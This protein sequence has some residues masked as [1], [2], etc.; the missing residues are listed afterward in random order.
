MVAVEPSSVHTRW[1]YTVRSG[2]AELHCHTNFSFLDGASHPEELAEEAH[3]LGLT[4]L[5]VTDHDGLYGVVRFAEAARPLGFPTIFGA[6]LTLGVEHAPNGVTEPPGEHVLILAEGPTGYAALART[7]SAAQLRGEKGA[8]QLSVEQLLV[9]AADA[10]GTWFTTTGCRKG[11]VPAALVRDGPSTAQH[12]LEQLVTA[13]GR[14]RVLVELWDHGDPLDRPR[15]DAMAQLAMRSGTEVIATNNVHYATPDRRQL[16]TALAA[17]RS[18]R[19]LDELDGWLPAAPF[20]HLRSAD[21]QLRRFARYPGAVERTVDIAAACAFDLKVAVP[22]LP[23]YPVPD[24][25]T[26]MSWLRELTRRGA[27]VYY[28]STHP[29]YEQ[30]MRQIDYE[31]GVIDQMGFPGYFLLMHDIVD[32]CRTHDIYCQGRGSAANSAVC[33][34][35]GVT[36]ADAVALGLLF[37][38]FLSTERDG[39]PDIDLDIEHQR[40]EEVIQYVYEKYGRDRAAQVANVITYRPR[41]ALREMAKVAG[42]SP[43]HADALTRWIDRWRSR[44]GAFDDFRESEDAPPVPELVLQLADAVQDFP[45]HLGIHSGGMVMAD[46]PL[47]ECC[48]VEWARMENRSVLQWDKDDCAAAGL[49]KFDLLGLGMLTMLHLAVDLVREHEAIDIDLATIPQEPEVYDLLTAADTIGVFQVES[50][51]QMATLPRLRPENFYDLVVEVALI[52]PGPIQG[53]SVHPY[54][55][56]RNGE[57]E[58]TY[59]HPLLEPCLRKTLGIP[60]FQEQLMQMAIDAAGFSAGEADQLRQAMGS[61]RSKARMARMRDR[62][63]SGMAERGIT[64][65]AATEI[66][67]KLEA[68]ASFGFPE[69]HSVSFAYLVY[70]SAWI[71]LHHPAEFACALLNAQPMGFYSPHTLVRDARRHGV[72]VLGPC[73]ERSRRDCTLEPRAQVVPEAP[74]GHPQPGWHADT[75]IHAMRIGLRYVRGLSSALLDRIDAEREQA[76]F[77][78]LEDFARRTEAPV[79][80]MESLA[81]AG[82]FACFDIDRRAGL[83]AAGALRDARPGHLPHT[84]V[85]IEAP[86]LPGM[87]EIEETAADLW[88]TGMSPGRHPTEFVR[89]ELTERGVVTSSAL[90][91]LPARSIVEV[92]GIVT[93]RQQPETAKGTVFL[94]LEDETG[95][96]NV[97]C[98]PGV[99]KRY[100]TVARGAPA[101]RVRGLLERHQG[102]VNLLAQRIEALP[103]TL[104]DALKSRDFR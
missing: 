29:H 39:P 59:P 79:D 84:A 102:V 27:S 103:L 63:M 71:K 1:A 49:V 7:I 67:H 99:W 60:L 94:N 69:S 82:V 90:R 37:E 31:L 80:A 55:R 14:D 77:R 65:E 11:I 42:L 32:F 12:A 10:R 75:S 74:I 95:L 2:Y 86:A 68:F 8:P 62:L 76:P 45:R 92:A 33:Y 19:S 51:A 61:K 15:N 52:R 96:T 36:K 20:A 21:E 40:R 83:W 89:A 13:F 93:H 66:A 24:G 78:D 81:T 47:V 91:E 100:R 98:P 35:L 53:G 72:E 3:R 101:L 25:H 50:R 48:P 41:S 28:P 34:A 4:G 64:G 17:I 18:R 26:D 5:A 6:E 58:V 43:G 85:G 54:L 30:A 46:R 88:A 104:A 73:L 57:E 56:R 87:T 23:E 38:R 70:A 97:I 22:N 16:A 9:A 44:E